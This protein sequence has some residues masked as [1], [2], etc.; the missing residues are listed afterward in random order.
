MP[1][2]TDGVLTLRP[3]GPQDVDALVEAC[4]DPEISRWT[5]APRPYRVF[6]WIA[7]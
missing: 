3:P 5:R 4:Q 7:E 1:I 6:A 2:L